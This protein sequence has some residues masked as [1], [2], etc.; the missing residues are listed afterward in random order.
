MIG[1]RDVSF[2]E[3]GSG[4]GADDYLDMRNDYM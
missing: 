2:D 4:G 1:E 3:D